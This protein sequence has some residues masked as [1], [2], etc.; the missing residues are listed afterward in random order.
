MTVEA[1]PEDFYELDLESIKQMQSFHIG[2]FIGQMNR[3]QILIM[4]VSISQNN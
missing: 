1:L 2:Q 4:Q 3:Y